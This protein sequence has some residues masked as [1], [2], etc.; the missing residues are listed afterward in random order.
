VADADRQPD[1]DPEALLRQ[2]QGKLSVRKLRLFSLACVRRFECFLAHP[3]LEKTR[4]AIDLLERQVEG[5]VPAEEL[6][7][8]R[9]AALEEIERNV[10]ERALANWTGSDMGHVLLANDAERAAARHIELTQDFAFDVVVDRLPESLSDDEAWEVVT[11]PVRAQLC[12][13][14]QDV[15]GEPSQPVRFRP[16][17]RTPDA[18]AIAS[19]MYLRRDF[20]A[21]PVL[22]EVLS[23]AGCEDPPLLRHCREPGEHIRGCW[24]VDL[25]LSKE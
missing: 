17:W 21:L 20:V 9:A 18:V 10:R 23:E 16:E 7:A 24:V 2:L 14:L 5:L 6:H 25:V 15:A 11:G 12:R 13:W 4:A 1:P 8:S 22:A 3:R 19:D